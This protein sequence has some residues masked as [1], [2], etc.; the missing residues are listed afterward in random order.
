MTILAR[1]EGEEGV[2]GIEGPVAVNG[3]ILQALVPEKI[4]KLLTESDAP[5]HLERQPGGFPIIEYNGQKRG[6]YTL[7][8]SAVIYPP[9]TVSNP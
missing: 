5:V 9:I 4:I 3:N 7:A 2:H 6:G 1:I 8:D